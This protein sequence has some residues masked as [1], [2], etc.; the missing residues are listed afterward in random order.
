MSREK[1]TQ[2][3]KRR[4]GGHGRTVE[5]VGVPG[6]DER[7]AGSFRHG[8]D[9]GIFEFSHRKGTRTPARAENLANRRLAWLERIQVA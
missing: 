9:N 2:K 4:D 6:D 8:R 1:S 5:V 3:L 7:G